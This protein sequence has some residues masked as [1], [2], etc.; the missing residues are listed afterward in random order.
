MYNGINEQIEEKNA[1]PKKLMS[2]LNARNERKLKPS[3]DVVRLIMCYIEYNK[4]S[5]IV[6]NTNKLFD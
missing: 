3:I 2:K 5:N 1:K 6:R 4:F